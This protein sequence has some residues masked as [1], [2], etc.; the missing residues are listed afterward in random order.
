MIKITSLITLEVYQ[1]DVI[2]K[3]HATGVKEV[4]D[5]NWLFVLKNYWHDDHSYSKCC[6]MAHQ[7]KYEYFGSTEVLVVTPIT[8][9]SYMNML[10]AFQL[11]L[12]AA[13]CGPAGVGKIETAIDLSRHLGSYFVVINCSDQINYISMR[14]IFK[15]VAGTG[16]WVAYDELNRCELTVLSVLATQ[17]ATVLDARSK[18]LTQFEL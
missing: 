9:R 18:K 5:A 10:N 6:W 4:D 16:C 2:R 3:L 8:E 15:G 1:N 7:Y 17:V 11:S 13:Q 12:G 14:E